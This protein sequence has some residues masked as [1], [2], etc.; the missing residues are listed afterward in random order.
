SDAVIASVLGELVE[1]GDID[2][3]QALIFAGVAQELW[4]IF[5]PADGVLQ[6]DP[7]R[8]AAIA[9]FAAGIREAVAFSRALDGTAAGATP[10]AGVRSQAS[11]IC[12]SSAI[13][14]L[15]S[16]FTSAPRR[17]IG[18]THHSQRAAG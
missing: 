15:S 17:G 11:G 16:D 14:P 3:R 2:R 7:K 13:R 18:V 1:R 9:G 12:L 6:L 8:R 5:R 10:T 4:D